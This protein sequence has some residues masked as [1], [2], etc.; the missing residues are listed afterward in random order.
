MPFCSRCGVEVDSVVEKCPLCEAPI[1]KL[2]M[3]NG[4]PWPSEEAPSPALPP[5]STDE[6][7]ALSRT[8]TTLGFLIPASFVLTVDW[9]VTRSLSWSLFALAS[10]GVAWLWALIP[11]VFNRKPFL[12]ITLISGVAII[13]AGVISILAG[14]SSWLLPIGVPVL[15]AAGLL[16]AG[17]TAMALKARRNGGN[18]AGW[19]LLALAI[20]SMIIDIL[21]SS[22]LSGS[23]K[24]GWSIIV[25][26]TLV[27]IAVLLLYLHYRPS[28]QRKLRQYFHV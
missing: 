28:R 6:R 20:L 25:V 15:T 22:W 8:I 10:L 4:S 16:S 13:G 24:P 1:Q 21:V 11:L 27:P 12:L 23:W 2:P 18:L 9:F 3:E 19:I 7:K 14:D 17:V 5:M 26:S